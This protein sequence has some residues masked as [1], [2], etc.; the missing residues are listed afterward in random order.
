M[1]C[2]YQSG[3]QLLNKPNSV[4]E[5]SLIATRKFHATSCWVQGSKQLISDI[6]VRFGDLIQQRGLARIG[7]SNQCN[8]RDART[9][10]L[11]SVAHAMC[12][13][14]FQ[15]LFEVRNPLT[16]GTFVNF[17]LR[18]TWPTQAYAARRTR[19]TSTT[20][21]L[22]FEMSPLTG[23]AWKIVLILREFY[24]QHT[25]ACM[26]MLCENIQDERRA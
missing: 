14:F 16:N 9:F 19:A 3:G 5:E 23:K 25:F 6:Y 4:G 10:P 17:K 15:F 21:R 8:S 18:F 24:L 22:P 26:C 11:R 2:F 12:T 7:I 1:E 13:N 20:T